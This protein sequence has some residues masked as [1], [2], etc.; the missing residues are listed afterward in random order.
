[1]GVEEIYE[2]LKENKGFYSA[3]QLSEELGIRQQTISRSLNIV[4]RYDDIVC[5]HHKLNIRHKSNIHDPT[6]NLPTRRTW[7]YAYKKQR[8]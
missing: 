5:E 6:R 2:F 3:R 7:V 1:M 8:S 4:S